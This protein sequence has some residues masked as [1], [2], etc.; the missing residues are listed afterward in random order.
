M[1][2]RAAP[3]A[4]RETGLRRVLRGLLP[5]G[6]PLRRTADRL[7]FGLMAALIVAFLAS[8]PLV[9]LAVAHWTYTSAFRAERAQ[10]AAWRPVTAVVTKGNPKG[11]AQL[12]GAA[13]FAQVPAA[14][15]APDG[16]AR[17]GKVAVPAGT[18][19]GATVR[20]WTDEAGWQTGPPL[21]QPQV[22]DQAMLA[23]VLAVVGLGTA[24]GLAGAIVHRGIERRRLAGWDAAWATAGP[25]WSN[26]R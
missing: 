14:W 24:A 7:E 19:K 4:S 1:S 5:D 12:Y 25:L 13:D 6:N 16:A 10:T 23:G 11:S 9:G 17:T 2:K 3:R 26:H 22:A 15:R 21:Q 8:A 20:I 18:G